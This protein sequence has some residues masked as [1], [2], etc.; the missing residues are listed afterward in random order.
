MGTFHGKVGMMG[1]EALAPGKTLPS[2]APVI[3]RLPASAKR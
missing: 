3:M 2:V 1:G